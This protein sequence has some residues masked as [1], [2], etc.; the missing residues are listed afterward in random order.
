MAKVTIFLHRVL[1]LVLF[2][3]SWTRVAVG[4]LIPW[5]QPIHKPG[6]VKV[7]ALSDAAWLELRAGGDLTN[8]DNGESK[9][10]DG[11]QDRSKSGDTAK[12]KDSDDKKSG[13][14]KKDQSQRA[15]CQDAKSKTGDDKE[16]PSPNADDQKKDAAK[17]DECKGP[18]GGDGDMGGGGG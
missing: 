16:N 8:Q 2:L 18:G 15:D 11:Q 17:P 9:T 7:F 6:S 10:T 14:E 13:E 3:F 12:S 1:T 4:R 5:Y